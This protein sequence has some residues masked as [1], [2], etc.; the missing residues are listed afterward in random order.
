MLRRSKT[1]QE[2]A[3][4]N[5]GIPF[6]KDGETC[7]VSALKS[8]LTAAN[9]SSGRVFRSVNRHGHACSSLHRGSIPYILKRVAQRAAI[10]CENLSGHSFRAGH[11]SQAVGNGVPEYVVMKRTGHKSR[12]MLGGYKDGRAVHAERGVGPGI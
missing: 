3:G 5:V 6:G 1:D 10:P 11:V 12:E 4:R 8:W 2:A 9:I 7:P